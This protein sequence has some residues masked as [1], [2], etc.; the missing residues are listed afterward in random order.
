MLNGELKLIPK[1]IKLNTNNR[2]PGPKG[3]TG[4]APVSALSD[5]TPNRLGAPVNMGPLVV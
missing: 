5:N 1:L 2:S 4:A 3:A